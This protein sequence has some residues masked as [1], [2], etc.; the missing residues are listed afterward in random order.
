[1][2]VRVCQIERILAAPAFSARSIFS[3]AEKHLSEPEGKS[4]L[5]DPTRTVEQK[6][7]RKGAGL[8]AAFQT[9]LKVF[10]PVK[11]GQRHG[12]IWHVS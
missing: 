1:M 7:G 5:P 10:V 3:L 8:E 6:A 9:F 12:V 2:E 11:A 4:L